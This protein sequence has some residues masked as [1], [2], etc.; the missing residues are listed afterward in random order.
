MVEFSF[1][2]GSVQLLWGPFQKA[3]V[4]RRLRKDHGK[5]REASLNCSHLAKATVVG[6]L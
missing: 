3:Y 4:Y 1:L 2:Y 5:S 6:A